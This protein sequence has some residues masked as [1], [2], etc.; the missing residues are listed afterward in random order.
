YDLQGIFELMGGLVDKRPLFFPF[1]VSILHDA[2]GYRPE[3]PFYLNAILTWVLLGL[4]YLGGRALGGWR[5]GLLAAMWWITLPLL[6]QNAR[7][8]GFELLNIVMIILTALASGIYYQR[9]DAT[10]MIAMIYSGILLAQTRYESPLFLL[11]VAVVL[12][13]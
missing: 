1:L 3:N 11:P 9:R 12:V 10:S 4:S 6:G 2:T 8:G 13:L 7:G 5:A